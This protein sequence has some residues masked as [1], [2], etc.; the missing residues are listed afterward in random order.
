MPES[1]LRVSEVLRAS[2]ASPTDEPQHLDNA[3]TAGEG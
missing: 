1:N 3:A 2:L